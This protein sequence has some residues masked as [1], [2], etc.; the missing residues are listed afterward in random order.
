MRKV[1]MLLF[2]DLFIIFGAGYLEL[3]IIIFP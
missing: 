3:Q 2:N 1:E